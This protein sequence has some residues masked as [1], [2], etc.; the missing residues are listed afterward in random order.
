MYNPYNYPW[1]GYG[2]QQLQMNPQQTNISVVFIQGGDAAVNNYLVAPNQSVILIDNDSHMIYIKAT[3]ASGMPVPLR[4][5]Q[6][7]IPA[8]PVQQP[9]ADYITRE[10][11]EKRIQE[12]TNAKLSE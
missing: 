7:D 6:E 1:N 4:K 10:E 2:S 3:D 8:A 9:Q 5:F 11:F 12:I